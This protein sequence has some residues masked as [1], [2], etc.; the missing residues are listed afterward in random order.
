MSYVNILNYR[1]E[2]IWPYF[3]YISMISAIFIGLI[4]SFAVMQINR[5]NTA[6]MLHEM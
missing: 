3:I 5:K 2:V 6:Q 1:Q 4:T